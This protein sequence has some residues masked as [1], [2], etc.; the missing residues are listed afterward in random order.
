[1]SAAAP[2]AG[3][4]IPQVPFEAPASPCGAPEGPSPA[5]VFTRDEL[6]FSRPLRWD[7]VVIGSAAPAAIDYL[8]GLLEAG[9]DRTRARRGI[10]QERLRA[11]LEAFVLDLYVA[12]KAHPDRFLAYARNANDYPHGRYDNP[13]VTVT[14]ART[15]ADF[16]TATGFAVGAPG[17]FN[18]T[19]NPFGGPGGLGRRTRIRATAHLVGLA[20]GLGISLAS[21]G[22]LASSETIRLKA[23][24][25][26]RG[27]TKPLVDYLDTAETRDMRAWLASIN[28]VIASAS[29]DLDGEAPDVVDDPADPERID[30]DD[31]SAKQIYRV[32]NNGRFDQGGR[33]FGGWWMA[34]SHIDRA[35]LLIDGE[36]TVEL[37]FRSLHARL[38]YQLEGQPLPPG[39]DPYSIPGVPDA[40]R[41]MVK[42]AVNRLLNAAPGS[43]PRE[44]EEA[45]QALPV[46][47]SW[48]RLLAMVEAHHK[49][50]AGWFR[51]GRGLHLQHID[52]AVANAVLG[53][54]ATRGVV[55][56][57]VHDSFI[58]GE[59]FERMLGETMF[60]AYRAQT[61]R[62]GAAR[63]YPVITGWTASTIEP[64]IRG[65]LEG[66]EPTIP[67]GAH[68]P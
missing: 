16:L 49:P 51:S 12:A 38:C 53:Y 10:D 66:M 32:F 67:D 68:T 9:E 26:Q 45:A 21:T 29:I 20:E 46:G 31:R 4:D 25:S 40:C 8:L 15:V 13:L 44:P 22:Y 57:P 17:F 42:A 24:A 3:S 61:G 63:A 48:R 7:R 23:A 37:D 6:E 43:N 34:L 35:R 5:P 18:R 59:S 36:P 58:V 60:N 30:A 19:A 62:F 41:D 47:L 52:S 50:I 65:R 54:L 28:S 1:M 39:V 2:C 56:L 64:T 14:A 27:A 55:C 33:F 11:T